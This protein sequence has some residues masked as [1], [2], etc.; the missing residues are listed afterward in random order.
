MKDISLNLDNLYNELKLILSI[1]ENDDIEYLNQLVRK[2]MNKISWDLFLELVF[3]HRVYPLL[4]HKLNK[5]DRELVP[6][7]VIQ[8]IN[9][10]FKK[11]TYRMLQFSGKMEKISK[12]FYENN[13]KLIFLKGPILGNEL[14]GDISLRACSDLDILIPIDDLHSANILLEGIGFIKD[15]YIKTILNDWKWRH[16]HVTYKH[17]LKNIKVEIHWRLHPGPG[18]EPDFNEIWER[19][20]VSNLTNYPV[21]YLGKEDLFLFLVNHGARHGWSRLRWLMDIQQMINKEVNWLQVEKLMKKQGS[22]DAIGQS[23]ILTS[24]LLK[25]KITNEMATYISRKKS[26]LLAY[27]AIFYLEQMVNLHTDPVPEVVSKFHRRY[28]FSLMTLQ[29]KFLYFLNFL[30]PYPA[31]AET[32]PL[33]K[34]FHFLYFPLRPF[35]WI[36]RKARNFA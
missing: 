19:K 11:N 4:V 32:L 26:K 14:Y 9:I 16:H 23:L 34:K 35:I 8:S 5:L 31:D 18:T 13:I 15:D 25:T 24:Q 27:D 2:N 30:Y 20:R 3:H 7:N 10:T 36:L 28:L 17:P 21:Y 6:Q 1:I 29:Q 12:L 22:I 33:P